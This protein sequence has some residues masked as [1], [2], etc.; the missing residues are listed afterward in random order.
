M[1]SPMTIA[2]KCASG[3]GA[4][5]RSAVWTSR[6]SSS[7]ANAEANCDGST[8]VA[9]QPRFC[10]SDSRKPTQ[11]PR[12][13]SRRVRP[14]AVVRIGHEMALDAQQRAARRLALAGGLLT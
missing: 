8:P 6:P 13:S 9:S 10:A 1:T 5:R 11:Q 14:G 7:R 4:V 3:S 12:S 2:S